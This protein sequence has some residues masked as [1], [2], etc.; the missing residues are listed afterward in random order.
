M[1]QPNTAIFECECGQTENRP[2]GFDGPVGWKIIQRE[3]GKFVLL[4][5]D[6]VEL[7]SIYEATGAKGGDEV[8]DDDRGT[9]VCEVKPG[10]NTNL[11]LRLGIYIDLSD[12]DCSRV[13]INDVAFLGSER[14]AA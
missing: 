1:N 11:F 9:V 13:S 2:E 12:P 5:S 6:C 4:C 3:K 10:V 8:T 7:A 14:I